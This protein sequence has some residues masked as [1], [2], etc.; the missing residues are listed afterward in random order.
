MDAVELLRAAQRDE[1]VA[2]VRRGIA[3]R[4]LVTQCGSQ[5]AASRV[6]GITQPAVSQQL[7]ALG[8]IDMIATDIVVDAAAPLLKQAAAEHG[9]H[10]LAVFG[11]TARGDADSTSDVDLLVTE[12]DGATLF[13]VARLRR[14]FE[15]ILA[16]PVDLVLWGALD[17]RDDADIIREA[18]RL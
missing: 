18:V 9:F 4:E 3:L 14:R 13:D 15:E 17:E 2:R 16:R 10:D 11:S 7:R 1:T 5:S 6:L 8:P 12:P